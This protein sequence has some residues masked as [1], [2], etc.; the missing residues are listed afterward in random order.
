[1]APRTVNWTNV[2]HI[3]ERLYSLKCL[4]SVAGLR[5]LRLTARERVRMWKTWHQFTK[6]YI[7]HWSKEI[8]HVEAMQDTSPVTYVV[9]DAAGEPIEG[10]FFRPELQKS[11]HWTTLMYMPFWTHADVGTGPSTWL[12]G[13]STHSA[14]IPGKATWSASVA[15][16]HPSAP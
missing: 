4:W 16:S 5:T 2:E 15:P 14:S 8:F 3:Q 6:G 1:M 13:S 10:T 9:A 7:G 12:D 11:Y